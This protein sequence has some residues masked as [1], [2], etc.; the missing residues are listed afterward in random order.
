MREL[1]ALPS[2]WRCAREDRV[3]SGGRVAPT[4]ANAGQRRCRWL[5]VRSGVAL[6]NSVRGG[7]QGSPSPRVRFSSLDFLPGRKSGRRVR[8]WGKV[9][10]P[11]PPAPRH[12]TRQG[13]AG[14]RDPSRH[15]G[16][17]RAAK[18]PPGVAG[19]GGCGWG[20][21]N[22]PLLGCMGLGWSRLGG[23][24]GDLGV[25]LSSYARAR[26]AGPDEPP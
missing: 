15:W 24:L 4:R 21:W 9:T 6:S 17:P 7:P 26:A 14:R 18:D 25:L 16:G 5:S 20:L 8:G 11:P 19:P 2:S 13:W 12:R 1:P 23:V 22:S 10:S 3:G